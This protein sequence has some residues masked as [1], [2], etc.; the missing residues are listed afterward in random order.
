MNTITN[1][2][3]DTVLNDLHQDGTAVNTILEEVIKGDYDDT[4]EDRYNAGYYPNLT[5]REL[6]FRIDYCRSRPFI[7]MYQPFYVI[8]D[9]GTYDILYVVDAPGTGTEQFESEI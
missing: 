4:R 6:K 7:Q 1:S 3:I 8:N 2:V 9:G 5:V